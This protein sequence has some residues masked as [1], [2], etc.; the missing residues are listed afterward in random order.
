MTITPLERYQ[1]AVRDGVLLPD[2]DQLT[3]V[4]RLQQCYEQLTKAQAA[5][6]IASQVPLTPEALH[7]ALLQ[8]ITDPKHRAQNLES[9]ISLVQQVLS[10]FIKVPKEPPASLGCYMYGGVGRGKTLLM[11]FFYESLPPAIH[12]KRT[13]FHR[14][15]REVHDLMRRLEGVEEPLQVIGAAY[16]S[17]YQVICLD[18]FVVIDI[19]DA[20]ILGGLTEAFFRCG[21]MVI[22]TSNAAPSDLYRDGLQRSRFLPA[23]ANL[24]RHL[25]LHHLDSNTDYRLR[26]LAQNP[27]YNVIQGDQEQIFAQ[28]F[29]EHTANHQ[30]IPGTLAVNGRTIAYLGSHVDIIWF[31]FRVICGPMRSVADYI[32]IAREHHTVLV[33]NV[34]QLSRSFE[35]QARRFLH[36]VDEFYDTKVKLILGASVQISELYIGSGAAFEFERTK[37]RL[38]EMQSQEYLSARH[39]AH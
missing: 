34:P 20:M 21:L 26:H 24:E 15:M 12:A 23:I 3:A 32:E 7:Q 35:D 9:P 31:D 25:L 16:A 6:R 1:G 18:E 22:T 19:T 14:F 8:T 29:Q 5:S 17:V 38:V 11:D 4:K 30:A 33:S 39:Q 10:W 37:S 36:L 28:L 27:T 2:P 13:H